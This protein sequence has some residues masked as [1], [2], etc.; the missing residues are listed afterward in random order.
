MWCLT[1]IASGTHEHAKYIVDLDIMHIFLQFIESP[2]HKI[3]EQAIWVIGNI[4]G[5]CNEFR[6][7]ALEKGS[8]E[9]I[10]Q[11]LQV[12]DKINVIKV[13][14][15]TISNLCRGKPHPNYDLV[16][17]A[18]P[19]AAEQVYTDDRDI[20]I[21]VL[22]TLTFLSDGED[23]KQAAVSQYGIEGQLVQYLE[24]DDLSIVV[25]SLR[26][27]GNL[28]SGDN[29]VTQKVIDAGALDALKALLVHEKD[30]IR[31]EAC[32]S[33]SN[34]LAGTTDQ[35]E[36]VIEKDIV[37]IILQRL[38]GDRFDIRK[39]A[40]WC[41]ANGVSGANNKQILYF[42]YHG[43]LPIL[44]NL[45]NINDMQLADMALDAIERC[46]KLGKKLHSDNSIEVN[47][48]AKHIIE[49]GGADVLHKFLLRNN[50]EQ[51]YEKCRRLLDNYLT[52]N[53][54]EVEANIDTQDGSYTFNVQ[55]QDRPYGI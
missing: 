12:E 25:P 21:D 40:A 17:D 23:E 37:P 3:R 4:A 46:L 36:Q 45:L 7:Y 27:I 2:N 42:T 1:N 18:I 30:G 11:L 33:L 38:R 54:N 50:N 8:M 39:E 10:L 5:D 52:Y 41:I 15:W 47:I 49:T 34:V 35:I 9:K 6:D 16:K 51:L 48:F 43:C 13:A 53:V 22:W 31:K 28:L 24:Y 55:D 44:C 26:I 29:E 32:W 14:T 20:L 19:Y